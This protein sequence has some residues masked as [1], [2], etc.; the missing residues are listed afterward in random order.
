MCVADWCL[1]GWCWRRGISSYWLLRRPQR[2]SRS[3]VASWESRS[4]GSGW[5]ICL[6]RHR[7]THE[8]SGGGEVIDLSNRVVTPEPASLSSPDSLADDEAPVTCTCPD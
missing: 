4:L 5:D 6:S 8:G 3:T 2:R 7:N 1:D